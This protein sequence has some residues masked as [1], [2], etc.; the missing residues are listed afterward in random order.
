MPSLGRPFQKGQRANPLG[1]HKHTPHKL[2]LEARKLARAEGPAIL[3]DIATRAKA[4]DPFSQRLF[5]HYMLPRSKLA[6][7]P[8]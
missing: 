2:T 6:E 8:V 4:G 5:M 7:E 1:N 3:K